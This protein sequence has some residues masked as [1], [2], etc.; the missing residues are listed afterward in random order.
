MISSFLQWIICIILLTTNWHLPRALPRTEQQRHLPSASRE[1]EPPAAVAADFQQSLRE[2]RWSKALCAPGNLVGQDFRQMFLGT[3]F[4]ILILASPHIWGSTKSL[5]SDIIPSGLT[6]TFCKLSASWYWTPPSPKLI[7][8]LSPTAALEQS[9]RAIWDA[10][11]QAAVLILPQIKL[12]SQLSSCTS[13]FSQHYLLFFNI[14]MCI[15]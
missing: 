14:S 2:F 15:Y 4:T 12:N 6:K 11:S 13:F 10:A 1:I 7:Y 9:F 5:H 8:R 3:D